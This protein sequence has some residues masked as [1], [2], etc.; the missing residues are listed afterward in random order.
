[1]LQK[2][3]SIILVLF[4]L[5]TLGGCTYNPFSTQNRLTGN[6]AAPLLGAGIGAGGLALLGAPKQLIILGGIGGGALGYYVSTL[7][8]DAGGIVAVGGQV[9]QIG[10]YVGIDIPTDYLFDHN[11][12]RLLVAAPSILDSVVD[13]LGRFGNRSILVAGHTSGFDRPAREKR[14]STARA[15]VVVD[16]LRNAG[17]NAFEESSI[18]LREIKYVGYGDRFPIANHFRNNSIRQNSH[19]LI[20]VYP[21]KRQLEAAP[22]RPVFKDIAT[23]DDSGYRGRGD[24]K[25]ISEYQVDC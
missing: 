7:R 20:S 14:L 24:N 9:Y 17:V 11:S 13:V 8:Y 21:S 23:I 5:C 18:N 25:C 10:D 1:M 3:K 4:F 22:Y 16:Y 12:A 2:V 19:I 15:K 6:P